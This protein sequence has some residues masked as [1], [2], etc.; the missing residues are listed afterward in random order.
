MATTAILKWVELLLSD[1]HVTCPLCGGKETFV[2]DGMITAKELLKQLLEPPA[3]S[4]PTDNGCV[5][6]WDAHCH[7]DLKS[8]EKL[9]NDSAIFAGA[10]FPSLNPSKGSAEPAYQRCG[11]CRSLLPPPFTS[12]PSEKVFPIAITGLAGAGKTTLLLRLLN[13]FGGTSGNAFRPQHAIQPSLYAEP[14]SLEAIRKTRGEVQR[15]FVG[16]VLWGVHVRNL[17]AKR[18]FSIP[19]I[20]FMGE[21]FYDNDTRHEEILRRHLPEKTGALLI[22]DSFEGL[23][24]TKVDGLGEPPAHAT[25]ALTVPAMAEEVPNVF[26]RVTA[27]LPNA[28]VWVAWTHLD[29]AKWDVP[30]AKKFESQWPLNPVPGPDVE[31]T[32]FTS[33]LEL[34]WGFAVFLSRVAPDSFVAPGIHHLAQRDTK[35]LAELQLRGV[36]WKKTN[37]GVW[38]GMSN[39]AVENMVNALFRLQKHLY[40]LRKASQS[41]QTYV[42][43]CQLIAHA[44]FGTWANRRYGDAPAPAVV[45]PLGIEGDPALA[46]WG[47]QILVRVDDELS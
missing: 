32:D 14:F 34:V 45:F 19:I 12:S 31:L 16:A 22:V 36:A 37:V 17:N 35:L 13:Q 41:P 39:A 18:S 9:L 6:W 2:V 40:E 30:T 20:D 15:S 44:L 24:D 38:K 5:G 4:D 47:D 21:R 1:D 43:L 3:V 28:R 23:P 10:R 29:K 25:P 27:A 11:R 7:G 26:S 33:A 46:V 8:L 42:R